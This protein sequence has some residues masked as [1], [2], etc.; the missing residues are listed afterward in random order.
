MNL[1]TILA[2]GSAAVALAA[3]PAFAVPPSGATRIASPTSKD[4]YTEGKDEAAKALAGKWT[5][6]ADPDGAETAKVMAAP[7]TAKQQR[8][9]ALHAVTAIEGFLARVKGEDWN[10]ENVTE[11]AGIL[12]DLGLDVWQVRSFVGDGKG[13]KYRVP[14]L[15][16][17]TEALSG[18]SFIATPL[19][20]NDKEWDDFVRTALDQRLRYFK[21]REEAAGGFFAGLGDR[22]SGISPQLFLIDY[23][24]KHGGQYF[25]LAAARLMVESLN[26]PASKEPGASSWQDNMFVGDRATTTDL[27]DEGR[28]VFDA[29]PINAVFYNPN[30]RACIKDSVTHATFFRQNWRGEDQ[31]GMFG[32]IAGRTVITT[33]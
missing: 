11:A 20:D 30:G 23:D 33:A 7:Q 16:Q 8:E 27:T 31:K 2:V 22:A 15:A 13:G 32:S 14:F 29:L 1:K 24:I 28:R 3:H 5:L 18:E 25:Y 19:I 17:V 9:T 21:D 6:L 26:T 12:R 10:S 4:P